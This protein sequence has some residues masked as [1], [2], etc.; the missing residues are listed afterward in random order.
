MSFEYIINLDSKES[1]S[2]ISTDLRAS[3]LCTST[4]KDYID[5]IDHESE[6]NI[7][8]DI[9]FYTDEE[10]SIFVAINCFSKNIFS[11]IKSILSK[12]NYYLVDCDTDEKVTL[13]YIFRSIL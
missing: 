4:T 8:Y 11:A 3:Q 1:T 12:Y 5:W 9:R 6:H 7:P 10:K 2:L 13:E